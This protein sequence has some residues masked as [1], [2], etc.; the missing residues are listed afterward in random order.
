VD[1]TLLTAS[2]AY[3]HVSVIL[4]IFKEVSTHLYVGI[5]LTLTVHLPAFF[6]ILLNADVALSH[7]FKPC[8]HIRAAHHANKGT[9]LAVTSHAVN[10]LLFWSSQR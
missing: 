2:L 10:N 3:F 8:F 5:L 9:T 1:C 4:S 7:C 6:Q